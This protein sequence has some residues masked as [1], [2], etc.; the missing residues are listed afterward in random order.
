MHDNRRRSVHWISMKLHLLKLQLSPPGKRLPLSLYVPNWKSCTTSFRKIRP[1]FTTRKSL[2]LLHDN[3]RLHVT[4]QML[5]K[6]SARLFHTHRVPQIYRQQTAPY[7]GTLI[8]SSCLKSSLKTKKWFIKQ[9]I[10][11]KNGQPNQGIYDLS[12]L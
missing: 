6:L 9:F 11:F 12:S 8:S 1:T 5:R 2:I 7:S 10:E 4:I 3:A